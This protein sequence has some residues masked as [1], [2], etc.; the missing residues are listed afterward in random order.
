M[1]TA[2]R[3]ADTIA[4]Y[5][6]DEFAIVL[7]GIEDEAAARAL[8]D[9][10]TETVGSEPVSLLGRELTIGFAAGIAIGDGGSEVEALMRDADLAMYRAKGRGGDGG[11]LPLLDAG[12]APPSAS[13]SSRACAGRWPTAG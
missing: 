5:G 2:L 9:R 8:T 13:R 12:P 4:R 3:P 11:A 6:G 7:E 10:L 1:R